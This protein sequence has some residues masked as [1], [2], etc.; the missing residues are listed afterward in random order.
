M[1]K[2]NTI[3]FI[4]FLSIF[5]FSCFCVYADSSVLVIAT[6][7]NEEKL[8]TLYNTSSSILYLTPSQTQSPQKIVLTI[9]ESD[10]PTLTKN[11]IPTTIIETEPDITMYTVIY[12]P[13]INTISEL[14]QFGSVYP[15]SK[16][17]S[18]V[19]FDPEKKNLSKTFSSVFYE[20]A[21]QESVPNPL[22][23]QALRNQS[24]TQEDLQESDIQPLL[25]TKPIV[26]DNAT[27]D[28]NTKTVSSVM[29]IVVIG[30]SIAIIISLVLFYFIKKNKTNS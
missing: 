4:V 10:I 25:Q 21:L 11:S 3:L 12:H 17:H 22:Q 14:S 1:K 26:S 24:F 20:T 8:Q 19:H 2:I 30:I 15:L 18:L 6:V 28:Q 9:Q 16:T 29:I 13:D 7:N 5:Y 27:N 23:I